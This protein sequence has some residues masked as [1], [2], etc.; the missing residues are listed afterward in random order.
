M[1]EFIATPR[2]VNNVT[3][4]TVPKKVC[5]AYNVEP[6]KTYIVQIVEIGTDE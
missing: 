3:I 1:I 4:V 5:D 2:I 6:K